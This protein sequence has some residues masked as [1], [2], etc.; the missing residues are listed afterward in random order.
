MASKVILSCVPRYVQFYYKSWLSYHSSN[1]VVFKK[2]I[3]W[4]WNSQ[5]L[6][7]GSF[8]AFEEEIID[9]GGAIWPYLI[10]IFS[11]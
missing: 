1:G 2:N 5:D 3:L 8:D 6:F 10:H 7:N 4:L 9:W 11:L